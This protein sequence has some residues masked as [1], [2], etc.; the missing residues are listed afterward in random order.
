MGDFL[1]F[2]VW[3]SMDDSKDNFKNNYFNFKPNY[4]IFF[5]VTTFSC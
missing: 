1:E 2:F 5:L 4:F 3:S